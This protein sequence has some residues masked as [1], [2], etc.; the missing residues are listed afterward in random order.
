MDAELKSA[1]WPP[2]CGE[3][4][5]G[6]AAAAAQAVTLLAVPSLP[7]ECGTAV[8]VQ[9]SSGE[10]IVSL[11]RGKIV[12]CAGGTYSVDVDGSSTQTGVQRTALTADIPL[13]HAEVGDRSKDTKQG[14]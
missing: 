14:R 6:A 3:E 1:V 10:G 12:S 13:Q 8:L 4:T 5:P 2:R 11:R 9:H 7:L